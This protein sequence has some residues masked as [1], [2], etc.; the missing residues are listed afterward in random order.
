MGNS[1]V[2]WIWQLLISIYPVYREQLFINIYLTA[3]F[4]AKLITSNTQRCGVLSREGWNCPACQDVKI[5]G[6]PRCSFAGDQVGAL[7]NWL[8][9][10]MLQTVHQDGNATRPEWQIVPRDGVGIKMNEMGRSKY[11]HILISPSLFFHCWST[12]SYENLCGETLSSIV[13]N[14]HQPSTWDLRR[15]QKFGGIIANRRTYC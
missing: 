11:S 7:F 14:G 12:H 9:D 8:S 1:F 13:I 6:S 4:R 2:K 3:N 5:A 15:F 10:H